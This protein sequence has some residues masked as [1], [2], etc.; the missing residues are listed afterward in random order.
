MDETLATLVEAYCNETGVS[1]SKVLS[2]ISENYVKFNSTAFI[3]FAVDPWGTA[4]VSYV[5]SKT[6]FAMTTLA[7]ELEA[8]L[9]DIGIKKIRAIVTLKAL[10]LVSKMLP[11]FMPE[12]VVLSKELIKDGEPVPEDN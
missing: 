3:V 4:E 10:N 11:G 1:H 6:P 12:E 2:Y 5:Y 9:R 7:K 8:E